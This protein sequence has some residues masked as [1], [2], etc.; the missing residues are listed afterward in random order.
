MAALLP[1]A[2]LLRGRGERR[3]AKAEGIITPGMLLKITATGGFI[4]H[5]VAG[6]NARRIV[7]VENDLMGQGIDVNYAIGDFVQAEE[8]PVGDVYGLVAAAAAAIA[9]GDLL[10]SAGNGTVRKLTTGI[11]IAEAL[12]AVNNSGGGAAARLKFAWI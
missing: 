3:E 5:N 6:A 4:P 12:E 11:A 10:E 1:K 9:V 8:V 7:A 2:I